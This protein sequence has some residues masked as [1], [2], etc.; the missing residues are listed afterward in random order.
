MQVDYIT[1][2]GVTDASNT[3]ASL[4]TCGIAVN[5]IDCDG[6]N[7]QGCGPG[8]YWET[9]RANSGE[10]WTGPAIDLLIP[11][12]GELPRDDVDLVD[13]MVAL[14]QT[15]ARATD[16][17]ERYTIAGRDARCQR[18]ITESIHRPQVT[19]NTPETP[20]AETCHR[21]IDRREYC[22]PLPSNG[23]RCPNSN[24]T[25]ATVRCAFG[26]L[27]IRAFD[28]HQ[29]DCA[30]CLPEYRRAK[31]HRYTYGVGSGAN[32]IITL[33]GLDPETASDARSYLTGRY[34]QRHAS[35]AS[36]LDGAITLITI[37]ADAIACPEHPAHLLNQRYPDAG[38]DV[39]NR[40]L[41]PGEFAALITSQHKV[42]GCLLPV[43]FSRWVKD[44]PA[45]PDYQFTD[46]DVYPTPIHGQ[47]PTIG[48]HHCEGCDT[49]HRD[50]PN[51]A[52]NSPERNRV[53]AE[54]RNEQWA[55]QH[56]DGLTLDYYALTDMAVAQ[57]G[58]AAYTHLLVSGYS[59]PRALL[60]DTANAL[61]FSKDAITTTNPRGA[62][63]HAYAS[64][65]MMVVWDHVNTGG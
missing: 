21:S 2:G 52:D 29:D 64:L 27:Q 11:D 38:V 60:A 35:I 58:K 25:T 6:E 63:L 41:S 39:V 17:W 42:A 53:N 5:P 20:L 7:C 45:E 44:A 40:I 46:P 51:R 61:R 65:A 23:L 13:V 54:R 56:L 3:S 9:E 55:V 34:R 62:Y 19:P 28:C 36:E 18:Q 24:W 31:A 32:T 47:Q 14:G 59:G 37:I 10:Y 43:T 1:D 15:G 4:Y 48:K 16:L 57:R 26:S 50:Y 22:P 8:C 49:V 30:V 12:P 33:T